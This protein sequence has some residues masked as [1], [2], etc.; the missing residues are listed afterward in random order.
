M[1]GG[2]KQRRVWLSLEAG[3]ASY[4]ACTSVLTPLLHRVLK[5]NFELFPVLD[6][7]TGLIEH[8]PDQ[9]EHLVRYY[10]FYSDASRGKRRKGCT[11]KA[12]THPSC[13]SLT[14]PH[15]ER[16]SC[17]GLISSNKFKR[18]NLCFARI[19]GVRR[20]IVW[21]YVGNHK[22]RYAV[23]KAWYTFCPD[24]GTDL[25]TYSAVPKERLRVSCR[26]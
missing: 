9:R 14:A 25:R 24:S 19:R 22:A 20:I 13:P 23:E 4:A 7:L 15:P 11:R 6:L 10:G 2:A 3:P 26:T 21:M 17:A 12:Q 8:I 5:R 1:R 16:L 18:S